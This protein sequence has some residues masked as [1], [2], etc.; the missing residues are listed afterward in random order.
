MRC[1]F[2]KKKKLIQF[3]CKC[4]SKYC[5]NCLP[6]YVHNCTFNYKENNKGEL[7]KNN[8]EIISPKVSDI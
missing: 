5:L 8:E 7:K 2:C 1:V 6:F 3:D 4:G